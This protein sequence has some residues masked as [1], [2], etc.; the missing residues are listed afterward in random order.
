M[1]TRKII[2]IDEE[3]CDGCGL[4]VP[5]CAEGAI[6]IIDGKARLVSEVYCD[7][8]GACLGECPQDA[9]I[10]EER[11]AEM[12]DPEAVQRHLSD[13]TIGHRMEEAQPPTESDSLACKCP[14]TISQMLHPDRAAAPSDTDAAKTEKEAMTSLLGNWP[15][16]IHLVPVRAPYFQGARLLIAADCVPFAFADFH[17][18]FLDGRTLLIG[19]PKLDDVD[20]YRSKLAQIFLENDIQTV[21]VVYM[22]VPCCFGL[23]HLV[24]QALDESRRKISVTFIKVG[25]RGD[26]C[27]IA[28]LQ[29]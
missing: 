16:Q 28:N 24:R 10:I 26:I 3:K 27:E 21:D 17:R 20:L 19:C 22:E 4:C 12:F 18:R 9:I 13:R 29:D 7:G 25:I 6:Q 23:V 14:G 8:L 11:E 15:V 2:K 1:V 5:A